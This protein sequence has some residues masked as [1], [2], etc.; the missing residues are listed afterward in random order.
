[1]VSIS[2]Y[3]SFYIEDCRILELITCSPKIVPFSKISEGIRRLN[4]TG[5]LVTSGALINASK[6]LET[7]LQKPSSL[8]LLISFGS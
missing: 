3:I 6:Y 7:A 8:G 4:T 1:M 2:I 5:L